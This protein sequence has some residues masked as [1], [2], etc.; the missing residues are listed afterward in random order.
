VSDGGFGNVGDEEADER[1]ARYL[2]A[3]S[4]RG[5]GDIP[6]RAEAA[7]SPFS[8]A[9]IDAASNLLEKAQ[10]ALREGNDERARQMVGRAVALPYD[11]VERA[12]PAAWQAHM[13]MFMA[14]TDA[15]EEDDGEDWL[16]AVIDTLS[17]APDEARFTL[18]DCVIDMLQ[19][20]DLS[21]H[22]RRRLR[23]AVAKVPARAELHKLDLTPEELSVAILDILAGVVHYEDTYAERSALS[24][25]EP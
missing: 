8:R 4:N 22:D 3:E 15:A 20:Y 16:D 23:E 2:A 17:T 18:R 6:L 5:F 10:R 11:D 21:G 24:D 13:C 12:H 1:F 14:V 9:K 19:D 7:V 25:G